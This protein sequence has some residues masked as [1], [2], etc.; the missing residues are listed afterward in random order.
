MKR[1]RWNR[2][3]LVALIGISMLTV[4]VA[5]AHVHLCL[6]GQE[7][8]AAVHLGDGKVHD[9]HADD[10]TTHQDLD[11][12]PDNAWGKT[13]K[14]DGKLP[15]IANAFA[16]RYGFY[17]GA[18]RFASTHLPLTAQPRFLRPQLRAPPL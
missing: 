14:S 3:L 15:F 9:Q 8:P 16:P 13:A 5:D 6:D 11:V 17:T 2:L 1:L 7:A 10:P 4:R 18:E 12:D